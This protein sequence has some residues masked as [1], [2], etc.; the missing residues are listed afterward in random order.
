[1]ETMGNILLISIKAILPLPVK[2]SKV[3][4]AKGPERI[5]NGKKR[6]KYKKGLSLGQKFWYN[7]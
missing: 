4:F 3:F 6:K 1:M 2:N 7:P 5:E